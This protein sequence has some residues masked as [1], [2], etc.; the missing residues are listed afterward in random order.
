MLLLVR[1]GESE[2]NAAGLL[3]GRIESPLTPAGH[4]QAAAVAR[5]VSG[6]EP[7]AR[8]GAPVASEGVSRV[9]SS[10]LGRARQTAAAV[11]ATCGVA[12]VEVDER[13]VELDYG[14]LDG[15]PMASV[16]PDLWA[17]WRHHPELI[18][19]H[20]E[21]LVALG[22]RVRSALAEL[23]HGTDS[24][25]GMH[26]HLV[27]VSHVSPIKAAVSWALGVADE[28][29]WRMWLAPGSVTVVG[30]GSDGPSLRAYNVCPDRGLPY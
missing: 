12:A 25:F 20:G 19:A 23:G 11:A 2:G 5:Q 27:V 22:R 15:R 10:P 3:L 1:H 4:R 7:D 30:W 26:R 18:P 21:S 14:D 8:A 16:P 29:V 6:R 17:R 9:V 24:W 13:W 28:T